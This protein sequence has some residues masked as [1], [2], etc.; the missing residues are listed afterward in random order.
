MSTAI[1]GMARG[2]G[3]YLVMAA[4]DEGR[5][6]WEV[7]VLGFQMLKTED[8]SLDD[9]LLLLLLKGGQAGSVERVPRFKRN[10]AERRWRRGVLRGGSSGVVTHTETIRC[11]S[12]AD[13]KK[14]EPSA[15][16]E[17]SRED[18]LELHGDAC[19]ELRRASDSAFLQVLSILG[20]KTP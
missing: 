10:E 6:T 15:Q 9:A 8:P 2:D 18:R 12:R 3:A 16:Q 11:V 17:V 4:L 13:K 5:L 1:K 7:V 20:I 14:A 19:F